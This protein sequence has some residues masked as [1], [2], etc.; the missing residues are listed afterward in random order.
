M[1]S[2][3]TCRKMLAAIEHSLVE[4]GRVL[5]FELVD[6]KAR[7]MRRHEKVDGRLMHESRKTRLIHIYSTL[8]RTTSHPL[9]VPWTQ[10]FPSR[11]ERL[12]CCGVAMATSLSQI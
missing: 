7:G 6:G 4:L 10:M 12:A 3:E 11:S 2:L 8:Y 1:H 9:D 5:R